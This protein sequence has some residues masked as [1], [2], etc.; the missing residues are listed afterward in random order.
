M[1]AAGPQLLFKSLTAMPG[2]Y[3]MWSGSIIEGARVCG[4]VGPFGPE[5]RHFASGQWQAWQQ[6][7][8]RVF[9]LQ[10]ETMR[11]LGLAAAA[12]AA[13]GTAAAG[14][15]I[16]SSNSST[17]SSSSA[18]V[19]GKC[20]SSSSSSSSQVKWRFLLDLQQSSPCWAAA[21]AEFGAKWPDFTL[22]GA[23]STFVTP[24]RPQPAPPTV[25]EAM[26]ADA[27]AV[28][29]TLAAEAPLPLVCNNPG[30]RNL[31]G[32]SEAAAAAKRCSGCKCR[33]CGLACQKADWK[34]HKPTCQRMAA[35]GMTCL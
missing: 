2:Y 25:A 9:Q 26:Y 17:N 28:C 34:R 12:P 23:Q 20:S 5:V 8:L 29:R 14:A 15:D 3:V 35:A 22:G 30:C 24:R 6:T 1:E 21:A 19:H 33:Y 11:L 10:L 18:A 4:V 32:V 13:A 16:T 7:V 31:A 27:V